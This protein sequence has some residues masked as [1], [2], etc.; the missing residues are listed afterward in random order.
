MVENDP[1]SLSIFLPVL[2]HLSYI[3][4]ELVPSIHEIP[5]AIQLSSRSFVEAPDHNHRSPKRRGRTAPWVE[6]SD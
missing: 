5:L 6:K 2:T 3:S 4:D 1:I